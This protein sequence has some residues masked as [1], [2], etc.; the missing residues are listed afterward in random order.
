MHI[1]IPAGDTGTVSFNAKGK[2]PSVHSKKRQGGLQNQSRGVMDKRRISSSDIIYKC[3]IPV[4]LRST[5]IFI[6]YAAIQNT[7]FQGN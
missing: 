1:S 4:V 7:N 6:L 3:H 2:N 5:D